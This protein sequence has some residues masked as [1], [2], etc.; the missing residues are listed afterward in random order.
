MK[1]NLFSLTKYSGDNFSKGG[2]ATHYKWC[3]TSVTIFTYAQNVRL[4]IK[5]T[6]L[7]HS[8]RI[9]IAGFNIVGA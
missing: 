4:L 7:H 9:A 5:M 1:N 8:T 2:G 3:S 6:L